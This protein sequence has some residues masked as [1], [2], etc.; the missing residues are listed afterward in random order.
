MGVR[1]GSWVATSWAA[2]RSPR[3]ALA[4]AAAR[5]QKP[6]EDDRKAP[7]SVSHSVNEDLVAPDWRDLLA[8]SGSPAVWL[9][10]TG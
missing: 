6:R 2:A 1:R 9:F 8:P 7:L 3:P 4:Q 10:G 5:G